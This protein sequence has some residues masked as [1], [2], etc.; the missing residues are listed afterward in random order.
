MHTRTKNI[1]HFKSFG[2]VC[3]QFIKYYRNSVL[4]NR[5]SALDV[6]RTKALWKRLV[7]F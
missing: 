4:S 6:I 1:Q 7:F 2:S 3:A 5:I